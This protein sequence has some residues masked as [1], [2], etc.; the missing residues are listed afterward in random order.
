MPSAAVSRVNQYGGF[1]AAHTPVPCVSNPPCILSMSMALPRT[2]HAF[3]LVVSASSARVCL[4]G[5]DQRRGANRACFIR[6]CARPSRS[7]NVGIW[8]PLSSIQIFP[9][10]PD[11]DS[12]AS[13]LR[14]NSGTSKWGKAPATHYLLHVLSLA[15]FEVG[16]AGEKGTR[17]D[18]DVTRPSA[19]TA[20]VACVSPFS[21]VLRR[22]V[23][24]EKQVRSNA[25]E[26]SSMSMSSICVSPRHH[27]ADTHLLTVIDKHTRDAVDSTGGHP[28][29]MHPSIA[30]R[31]LEERCIARGFL[32][33]ARTSRMVR[34]PAPSLCA[35]LDVATAVTDAAA[36]GP[37]FFAITDEGR[38]V[39]KGKELGNVD[40]GPGAKTKRNG[41][42]LT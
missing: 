34:F 9:S 23:V 13:I 42:V 18:Y 19:R 3:T 15:V 4:S 32:L 30:R 8:I 14:P 7:Q 37:S 41:A 22:K 2:P 10:L 31:D 26:V 25:Q 1:S 24:W 29:Q 5:H 39:R 38:G 28:R 16:I 27:V 35:S 40:D 36:A 6:R 11:V 17:R 12:S 21:E 20:F 33:P